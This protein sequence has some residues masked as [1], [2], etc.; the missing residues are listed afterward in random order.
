[1]TIAS[2]I[3][4]WLA[5]FFRDRRHDLTRSEM[6]DAFHALGVMHA[7]LLEA[8]P[9]LAE[10]AKL[11]REHERLDSHVTFAPY[12]GAP[13]AYER[14]Q[15]D[16]IAPEVM[17]SRAAVAAKLLGRA[18]VDAWH[19]MLDKAPPHKGMLNGARHEYRRSRRRMAVKPT[20]AD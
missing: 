20:G 18:N 8:R 16:A 13:S 1:M 7:N 3:F 14:R 15:R 19:A 10:F 2:S 6:L 12:W 11:W 9:D 5:D 4:D 17:E